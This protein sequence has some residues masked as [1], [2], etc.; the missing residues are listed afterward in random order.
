[1]RNYAWLSKWRYASE[2]VNNVNATCGISSPQQA[3]SSMSER[4]VR[5]RFM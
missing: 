4:S 5:W 3:V 1:M 2:T